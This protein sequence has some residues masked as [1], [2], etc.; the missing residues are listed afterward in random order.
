ML[1]VVSWCDTVAV[2][3]CSL[4]W[5]Q[6]STLP[7]PTPGWATI[8]HDIHQ[9]KKKTVYHSRRYACHPCA[10]AML[11]FSVLFIVLTDVLSDVLVR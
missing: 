8:S 9:K 10:G 2:S 11:I 3:W 1:L 4:A 7:H 6:V 5:P